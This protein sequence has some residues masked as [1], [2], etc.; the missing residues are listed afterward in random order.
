MGQFD[1]VVNGIIAKIS[2]ELTAKRQEEISAATAVEN[3]FGNVGLMIQ[4]LQP[5]LTEQF[6]DLEPKIAL[7]RWVKEKDRIT[8]TLKLKCGS[9]EK[10][11][12][13]EV[14]I[15]DSDVLVD[16]E[17]FPKNRAMDMLA[18]KIAHFY[19]SA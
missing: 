16:R 18:A 6:P 1:H 15:W 11:I 19:S 12:H 9:R 7:G 5:R 14:L 17:A 4:E 3:M 8:N 10:D 13:L 2:T